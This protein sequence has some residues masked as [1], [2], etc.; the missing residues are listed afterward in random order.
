MFSFL[1]HRSSA[2]KAY[3]SQGSLPP[4]VDP[5]QPPSKKNP[6][7]TIIG[8]PFIHTVCNDTKF[9]KLCS[10]AEVTAQVQLVLPQE[11]YDVLWDN[12]EAKI[13]N[14]V[15]SRVIMS[16]SEILEG[17]FFNKYIKTGTSSLGHIH[18]DL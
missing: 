18:I 3:V 13:G 11:L 12:V 7:S 14:I 9:E 6:F 17:E 8:Q 15:Y 16:L 1:D 2:A 10:E 5:E 4:F